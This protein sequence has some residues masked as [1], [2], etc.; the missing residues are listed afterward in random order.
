MNIHIATRAFHDLPN[1]GDMGR[2]WQ[3][4]EDLM[5]VLSDGLG[6]GKEAEK[7]S[8]AVLEHIDQNPGRSLEQIFADCNLA[9][10][11]TRGVA[12]GIALVNRSRNEFIFAGIG[13]INLVK[14][15]S[16]GDIQHFAS[17]PGIVG[18]GYRHLRPS[19]D[20]LEQGDLLLLHTDGI[21]EHM[22]L[23]TYPTQHFD[24]L[25]RLADSVIK[26][27]GKVTDD[28]GLILY[29]AEPIE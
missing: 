4:Q 12:M 24:D 16:D 6:H 23:S 5:L 22:K 8:Q 15:N 10:N 26:D 18:G 25:P 1:C 27:W 20:K 13:N 28:A 3:R 21:M 17:D 14:R 2:W 29:K 19:T 7:A 9:I 11:K